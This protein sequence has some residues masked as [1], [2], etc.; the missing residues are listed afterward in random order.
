MS[1][2]TCAP[3]QLC[4]EPA[5]YE[6]A[7]SC[8]HQVVRGPWLECSKLKRRVIDLFLPAVTTKGRVHRCV[9][10][11]AGFGEHSMSPGGLLLS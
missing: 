11:K 5:C 9:D 3:F 8:G 2:S 7:R 6:Q 1:C 10:G 4:H